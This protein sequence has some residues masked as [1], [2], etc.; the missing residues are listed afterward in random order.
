MIQI[1][2][3]P[4]HSFASIK[5]LPK[6]SLAT[7][8][9]SKERYNIEKEKKPSWQ[10][11]RRTQVPSACLLLCSWLLSFRL[12]MRLAQVHASVT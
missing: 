12:V 9:N 4:K 11:S 2:G 10:Y 5:V 1:Y 8:I 7:H 3:G 6:E